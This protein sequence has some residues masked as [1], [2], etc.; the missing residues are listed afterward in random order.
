MVRW[1]GGGGGQFLRLRL[2]EFEVK[3]I[4]TGEEPFGEKGSVLTVAFE[5]NGEEFVLVGG[6][7]IA[8]AIAVRDAIP[9]VCS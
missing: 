6:G 4:Y 2:Q 9:R 5:L 7:S 1:A 3:E 8:R